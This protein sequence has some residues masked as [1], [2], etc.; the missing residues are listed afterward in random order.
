PPPTAA[1]PI[2]GLV[3]ALHLVGGVTRRRRSARPRPQRSAHHPP[4]GPAAGGEE[5]KPV[6][7]GTHSRASEP[8]CREAR[9][10]RTAAALHA[11]VVLPL[12]PGRAFQRL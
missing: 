5:R 6:C 11:C 4:C 7:P 2:G 12:L 9:A 1:P 8:R 3:H 10:R